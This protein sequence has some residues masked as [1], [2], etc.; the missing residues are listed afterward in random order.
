MDGGNQS[1]PLEAVIFVLFEG[2]R[3]EPSNGAFAAVVG[4]N[5]TFDASESTG[6]NLSF[7]WDFGDG[8]T[9]QNQTVVHAYASPGVF[10][11]AVEVS[12]PV[13]SAN[14]AVA[15]NVSASGP[16]PGQR[17]GTAV[18]E[19]TGTVPVGNPNAAMLEDIDHVNHI[20]PITDVDPN[21]TAGAATTASLSL[22]SSSPGALIMY[23]YWIDAEG[24]TLAS[25][26][27]DTGQVTLDYEGAMP[28]GDYVLRVRL[29]AGAQASYTAGADIG[30]VA[31]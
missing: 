6:T 21:G 31:V 8:T 14:A 27:T 11:A 29:F 9:G 4:A 15:I 10:N 7:S 13:S 26:S 30:Y 19:F 20:V 12:D 3:L 17:I 25:A 24:T 2:S 16:S 1:L 23:V 5:L 28:P 22:E 18:H